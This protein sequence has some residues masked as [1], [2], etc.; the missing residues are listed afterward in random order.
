MRPGLGTR[1]GMLFAVFL[2]GLQ[3]PAKAAVS[4]YPPHLPMDRHRHY[5]PHGLAALLEVLTECGLV[6]FAC[7]WM[8][9]R[10]AG[11]RHGATQALGG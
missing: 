9:A 1:S 10:L 7:C 3:P 2:P 4:P 11:G 6:W 5:P 8:G